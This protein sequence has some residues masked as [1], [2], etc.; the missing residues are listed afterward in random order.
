MY[1]HHFT[2]F[3]YHCKHSSFRIV[4]FTLASRMSKTKGEVR[5][6]HSVITYTF[7][8]V[9]L[10]ADSNIARSTMHGEWLR[11]LLLSCIKMTSNGDIVVTSLQSFA[12]GM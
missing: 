3:A 2:L 11:Y 4:F 1:E 7:F 5:R 9:A 12:H 10:V 6:N 8:C